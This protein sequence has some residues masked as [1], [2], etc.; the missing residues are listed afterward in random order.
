[1]NLKFSRVLK[2]CKKGVESAEFKIL[3][4]AEKM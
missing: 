1:M 2:V 4:S 3:T